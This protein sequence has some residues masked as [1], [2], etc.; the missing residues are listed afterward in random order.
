MHARPEPKISSPCSI[1]CCQLEGA[2]YNAPNATQPMIEGAITALEMA[3]EAVSDCQYGRVW[4][5]PQVSDRLSRSC[6]KSLAI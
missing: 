3:G 1:S 4:P 5:L 6:T 2:L